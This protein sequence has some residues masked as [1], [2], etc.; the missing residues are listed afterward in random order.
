MPRSSSAN[1]Y[2]S[3]QTFALVVMRILGSFAGPPGSEREAGMASIPPSSGAARSSASASSS[4]PE[5]WPA[6]VDAVGSEVRCDEPYSR[7][8][9][10]VRGTL[11]S[12]RR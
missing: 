11:A 12:S 6:E 1:A 2:V 5:P 10:C 3:L 8:L 4:S 9:S 7:E